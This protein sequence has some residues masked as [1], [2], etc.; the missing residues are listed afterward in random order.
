L[1]FWRAKEQLRLSKF[2]RKIKG[3]KIK[4]N[5]SQW[6]VS[7]SI[8]LFRISDIYSQPYFDFPTKLWY[9]HTLMNFNEK[10]RNQKYFSLAG[11]Y[12]KCSIQ[13]GRFQRK[14]Y[15]KNW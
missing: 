7:V 3:V 2:K 11:M 5:V 4:D 10:K 6:V 1:L 12:R 13:T 8:K 9:L 14:V 15:L